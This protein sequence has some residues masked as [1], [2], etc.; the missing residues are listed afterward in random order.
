MKSIADRIKEGLEMR[1]MKQAELVA[2]TGIGKSSISTY[3]SGDYEP[4]QRNLYKIAKALDVDVSW[5]M[6]N[7]VPAESQGNDIMSSYKLANITNKLKNDMQA[8]ELLKLY[9]D[10]LSDDNRKRILDLARALGSS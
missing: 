9:Y 3:I 2:K 10:D 8:Q 6:G 5:L 4:K 7:D 1:G